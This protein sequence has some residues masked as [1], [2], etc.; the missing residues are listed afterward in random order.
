[1]RR[2]IH[3]E[4]VERGA[5]DA[6]AWMNHRLSFEWVGSK[7]VAASMFKEWYRRKS[8]GATR[9]ERGVIHRPRTKLEK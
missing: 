5:T 8:I 9:D 1:M 7:G 6:V 4:I 3:P 2:P